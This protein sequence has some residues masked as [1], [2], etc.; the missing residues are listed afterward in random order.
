[1]K[2]GKIISRISRRIIFLMDGVNTKLYMK[3]YNKWLKNQRIDMDGEA[4]FIH[5]SVSFDGVSYRHIH[6]GNNV[7]IS[8]DTLILVHDFS[9]EAGLLAIGKSEAP[10]VEAYYVKD[11]TIGKDCFI[12]AKSVVLGGSQ[13]GDHCIIGAG[14]V[15][16][17]KT[18]PEYSIIVGNPGRVIGD[19]REWAERKYKEGNYNRGY[20]N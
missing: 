6:I 7:V 1:M 4:K 17:G 18:Y 13:I 16:P 14:T 5:H 3:C 11:V 9:L 15:I 12:G 10:S 20:L 19:V 2:I 8:K